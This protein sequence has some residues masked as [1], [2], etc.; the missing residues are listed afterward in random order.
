MAP[1]RR[2]K[3]R[4]LSPWSFAAL[5]LAGGLAAVAP[6]AAQPGDTSTDHVDGYLS[7]SPDGRCA[8]LKQHDGSIFSLSGRWH[9]LAAND[10][11][12]LEGHLVPDTRCGGQGGFAITLVQAIWADD[13]HRSTYYD[14]LKDGTFRSWAERN[15]PRELQRFERRDRP[16]SGG[17]PPR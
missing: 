17:P 1:R 16:Y 10:H 5:V 12:R 15:R 9:G 2:T 4:V 13:N 11:V 3:I 7:I 8:V 6:A 14:H